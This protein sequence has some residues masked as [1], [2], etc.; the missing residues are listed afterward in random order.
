[1]NDLFI[2]HSE[3]S[4]R[5]QG[6]IEMTFPTP[7]LSRFARVAA[8][9]LPLIGLGTFAAQAS[10]PT[11][12]FSLHLGAPAHGHYRS[13]AICLTNGE[14]AAQ[15]QNEGLHSVRFGNALPHH[16]VTIYGS[17]HHSDYSLVVDRCSGQIY[18]THLVRAAYPQHYRDHHPTVTVYAHDGGYDQGGYYGDTYWDRGYDGGYGYDYSPGGSF[19]FGFGY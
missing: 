13:Q 19:Q 2:W 7:K 15:L 8:V 16:A 10:Q 12:S 11:V 5:Q 3:N 4:A 1:M 17:W 6:V 9:A 18:G 14:I